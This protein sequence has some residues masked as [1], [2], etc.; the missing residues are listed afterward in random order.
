MQ[1]ELGQFE[2][3]KVWEFVHRPNSVTII[4]TKWIYKN[5]PYKNGNVIINKVH[6]IAQGYAR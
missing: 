4:G 1:E 5:K 2:R 6:I 3:N